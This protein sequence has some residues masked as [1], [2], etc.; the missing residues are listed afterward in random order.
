VDNPD[1]LMHED[2]IRWFQAVQKAI[3][4]PI[5]GVAPEQITMTAPHLLGRTTAGTV[6]SPARMAARQRRSPAM[7]WNRSPSLRTTI[8][9][10]MPLALIDSA[11]SRSRVSEATRNSTPAQKMIPSATCQGMRCATISV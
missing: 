7:I 5:S 11:S 8:G 10:M 2:W 4:T 3:E 9:W 1:T 6:S